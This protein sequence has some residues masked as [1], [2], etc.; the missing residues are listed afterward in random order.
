MLNNY[1]SASATIMALGILVCVL[2]LLYI[3][4]RILREPL[5]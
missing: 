1:S 2:V 3:L 5:I 4:Y